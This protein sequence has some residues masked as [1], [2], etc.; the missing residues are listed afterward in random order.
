MIKIEMLDK[1]DE[2]KWVFTVSGIPPEYANT[3]RRLMM[4]EVP[5]MAIE[6]VEIRKNNSIL[7][8][9]MLAHRLGLVPLTTDLKG[10]TA[11]DE[12]T[13]N[14]AGC[15][16]CSVTLTLKE[17]GPGTV[18]ASDLKSKD[19]AVKPVYPKMPIAKLLEGQEI[20]LEAVAILGR[21]KTHSK[22][23]TG[24]VFYKGNPHVTVKKDPSSLDLKKQIVKACPVS[25]FELKNDK[26]QVIEKNVPA[27]HLCAA[28]TDL[29]KDVS[30][31]TNDEYMF[32]IESFGQLTPKE[33]A[34]RA[35]E[36][37]NR[38]LGEFEELV[39]KIEA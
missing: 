7:Y 28:C 8:D 1:S 4:T 37:F 20:E 36:E 12:C 34:V 11:I 32:T 24:L 18:Y 3:L 30:V 27:C 23:N 13:C 38:Q 31:E 21:G 2:N 29:S 33:I 22:W 19:P 16:K 5:V 17:K 35:M 6:D 14:G 15:N 10:Y 26:L 25:I 39:K 9:E